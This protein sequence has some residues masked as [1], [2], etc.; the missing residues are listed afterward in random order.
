MAK[1]KDLCI[2]GWPRVVCQPG[3]WHDTLNNIMKELS[4]SAELS[5]MY[6]N[7]C[8]HVSVVSTLD[9]SGF[10]SHHIMHITS[11]KS[12]ES[13]K[14]YG[15]RCLDSKR[16]AMF[17]TLSNKMLRWSSHQEEKSSQESSKQDEDTMLSIQYSPIH[18]GWFDRGMWGD[19]AATIP[20]LQAGHYLINPELKGFK[21]HFSRLTAT[22]SKPPGTS[23][24]ILSTINKADVQDM[25]MDFLKELE[26]NDLDQEKLMAL[27]DQIEKENV[28]YIEEKQPATADLY[29]SPC[30]CTQLGTG[31]GTNSSTC[32]TT[33]GNQCQQLPTEEHNPPITCSNLH[34][35]PFNSYNQLQHLQPVKISWLWTVKQAKQNCNF[36][37]R[38]W[39]NWT[40]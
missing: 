31:E 9:E 5:K 13:L 37:R 25:G 18:E 30:S 7:H 32:W 11:H 33:T 22:V 19:T 12:E 23:N 21:P 8:I 15:S 27:V 35:S 2:V 34:L 39:E 4:K 16:K 17:N 26:N 3:C 40:N 38:N 1:T 36:A 20:G 29:T 10:E 28:Q 6:M 24:T 14:S